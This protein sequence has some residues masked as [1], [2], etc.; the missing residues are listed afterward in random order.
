MKLQGSIVAL[1][2]PFYEDRTVNFERLGEILDWYIA[3]GT[4]GILV[5]GTTGESSTM[6][7]EEDDAVCRFTIGR[8]AGRVPVIAGSGSNSTETQLEKSKKYA[9]M[10]ADALLCI[11]PYYIKANAEGMYRH[12]ANVA[13]AV[14]VPVILYNVPGRTGCSIP[15]ETVARLA[16]HPNIC[17]IKE[18]SGDISYA[19]KIARY[20]SDDFQRQ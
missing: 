11:T 17:G 5:L 1:I 4:D 15:V 8:V 10:G 19:V 6:S 7:H 3:Q 12:F 14:D 18:A 13:D 2:T 20:L 9:A 16:R